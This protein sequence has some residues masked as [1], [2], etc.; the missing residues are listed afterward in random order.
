MVKNDRVTS[1]SQRTIEL[2]QAIGISPEPG[3]LV[4]IE[5]GCGRRED[6]CQLKFGNFIN[7]QGFPHI[8][9]EDWLMAYPLSA[10][11]KDGG[12]LRG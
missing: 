5:A 12:S 6:T 4:R 9:G 2:W 3:D 1:A 7:F 8:P 10:D 11:I